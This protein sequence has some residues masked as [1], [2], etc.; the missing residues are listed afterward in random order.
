MNNRES[1]KGGSNQG[2]EAAVRGLTKSGEGVRK[3]LEEG[4]V[5]D[6]LSLLD[7][8]NI[9][10][11]HQTTVLAALEALRGGALTQQDAI[12]AVYASVGTTPKPL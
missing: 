12:N 7:T 5:T 2:R 9:K 8:L 1:R 4:T 6:M 3:T 10:P 11:D